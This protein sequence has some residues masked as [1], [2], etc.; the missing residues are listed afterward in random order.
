MIAD[1]KAGVGALYIIKITNNIK[2]SSFE[3]TS[4][5]ILNEKYSP[6]YVFNAGYDLLNKHQAGKWIADIILAY[7][8][9]FWTKAKWGLMVC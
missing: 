7:Q 1:A 2:V 8:P 4:L 9:V 3:L 5:I 6:K